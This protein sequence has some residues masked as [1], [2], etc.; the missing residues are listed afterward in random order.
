MQDYGLAMGA[1]TL[2]IFSEIYLQYLENTTI[3]HILTK[4][5]I[6]VYFRYVDDNL[7]VYQNNTTNIHKVLNTFNNSTPTMH[8][9]M[10]EAFEN[11][12]NFLD[13]TISK[14]SNNIQFS[15]YRKLT[16]IHKTPAEPNLASVRYLTKH[17]S[18]Y[19]VN[20]IEKEIKINTIKQILRNN[21]CV[22][23]I[24]NKS[25]PNKKN[26]TEQKKKSSQTRWVKI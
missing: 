22:T 10:E 2:S 23:A 15:L 21:K 26:E 13:T 19:R 6:L 16:A 9:T 12:T 20:N 8:F 4:H 17:L 25:Q 11:K 18:I 7:V 1:P 24:L 14:D 3:F 5:H